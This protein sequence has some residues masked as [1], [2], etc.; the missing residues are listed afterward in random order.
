[1]KEL[2]KIASNGQWALQKNDDSLDHPALSHG[3]PYKIKDI[4]SGT[5]PLYLSPHPAIAKEYANE[6]LQGAQQPPQG[7]VSDPGV[8]KLS[9]ANLKT[10]DLRRPDH[11]AE[12]MQRREKALSTITD[13]DERASYPH[14]K[15]E[16]FISSKT[17]L[18]S[19]GQSHIL[20]KLFPEYDA[21][22]LDEGSQGHSYAVY[23]R[24]KLKYHGRLK[25][26]DV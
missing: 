13:P 21:H 19:Y 5:G 20:N 23:N 1:M 2:L 7:A 9:A 17:G 4:H 14:L 10:L 12:Y 6:K 26:S 24:Q 16:G 22:L 18:P 25:D 8:H 15:K 3:S 11:A